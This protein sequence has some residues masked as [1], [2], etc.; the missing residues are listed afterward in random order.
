ARLVLPFP[1]TRNEAFPSDILLGSALLGELIGDHDFRGDPGVIGTRLPQHVATPH[2]LVADQHI[3]QGKGQ[4]MTHMQHPGHVWRRHHDGVRRFVAVVVGGET[5]RPLPLRI[6]GTLEDRGL[7]AVRHQDF[8]QRGH[9]N[10]ASP[11]TRAISSRTSRSTMP[12][13]WVSSQVWSNGRSISRTICSSVRSIPPS[14]S[15]VSLPRS[16]GSA[17]SWA[18]VAATAPEVVA[19]TIRPP[20]VPNLGSGT[21]SACDG[22][23]SIRPMGSAG[24]PLGASSV[25][26]DAVVPPAHG[27]TR[28]TEPSSSTTCVSSR[29]SVSSV[30]GVVST[31]TVAPTRRST[32]GLSSARIRLTEAMISSIEGSDGDFPAGMEAPDNFDSSWAELR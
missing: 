17:P 12:G 16:L 30:V 25:R 24:D 1:Y 27:A 10:P 23:D 32:A 28:R 3:L 15:S 31:G 20:P 19:D 6:A 4:R 22:R 21:G 14:G 18:N 9:L 2:P 5:T 29:M 26:L 7:E 13:R 8:W 11:A